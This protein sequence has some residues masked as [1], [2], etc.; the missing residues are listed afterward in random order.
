MKNSSTL[1]RPFAR[2]LSLAACATALALALT[3]VLPQAVSAHD[4]TPPVPDG[5]EVPAGNRLFLVGHA[6]GTQNYICR[7]SGTAFMWTLFTPQATLFDDDGRQLTTH[8]FSPN[9]EENLVRPAWQHSRDTSTFWGRA[10]ASSTDANF[11]EP[12]A[13]PWLKLERAGTAEGP[14]GGDRLAVTTFV[15]RLNTSGGAAPAT[16]CSTA[17]DVGKTVFV[18]YSADYFFYKKARSR[19]DDSD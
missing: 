10:I 6:L 5:L 1:H 8:F 15:Q 13:I 14:T 12:G 18:P 4:S 2:R 19:K 7:P 11:V 3:A 16:G 9:P 17:A